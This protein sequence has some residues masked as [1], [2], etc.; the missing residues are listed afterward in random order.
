ME[1]LVVWLTS[2]EILAPDKCNEGEVKLKE[3]IMKK[4][5]ELGFEYERVYHGCSPCTVAPI[6]DLFELDESVFKAS[7][8]LSGGVCM[9]GEGPCGALSAGLLTF[10]YF[11][12]RNRANFEKIGYDLKASKYGMELRQKFIDAY[13]SHICSE[14]HKRIFGRSFNLLNKE[15]FDEFEKAGGHDQKCPEVIGKAASWIVELLMD[16]KLVEPKK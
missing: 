3:E 4:A 12:G 10:G 2:I 6:Q 11:C 14:I 16:N 7:T 15:D 13:S 9:S 1:L 8:T 5:Y